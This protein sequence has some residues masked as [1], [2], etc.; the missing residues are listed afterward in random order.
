MI[1]TYNIDPVWQSYNDNEIE[2]FRQLIKDGHDVNGLGRDGHSLI[3]HILTDYDQIDK[4]IKFF[5]ELINDDIDFRSIIK[6]KFLLSIA[7]TNPHKK[8][9]HYIKKLIKFNIDIN[10]FGTGLGPSPEPC[11]YNSYRKVYEPPIFQ[12]VPMLSMRNKFNDYYYLLLKKNPD[13]EICNHNGETIIN[14]LIFENEVIGI[15]QYNFYSLISKMIKQGA[16]PTQRSYNN[17]CNSLHELCKAPNTSLNYKKLFDLFLKHGCDINSVDFDGCTP[18]Q[19]AFIYRN[20]EAIKILIKNGVDINKHGKFNM[21]VIFQAAAYNNLESFN[22]FFENNAIL[23]HIL[24]NDNNILHIMLKSES[25]NEH[26]YTKILDKNPELLLMK[27]IFGKTP[28]D[29][30]NNIRIK[31]VKSSLLSLVK[32]YQKF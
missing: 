17:G 29:I 13:L 15:N 10:S 18:L 5:D 1:K 19:Y 6:Q 7:A 16:D 4:N 26:F 28:I 25:Y 14:Y 8:S 21:P 30:I 24:D 12:S 9:I 27:D 23:T 2:K 11:T 22:I 20:L 32:K 31:S 3:E